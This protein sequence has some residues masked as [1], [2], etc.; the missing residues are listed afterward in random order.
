[1]LIRMTS[2]NGQ[3][4]TGGEGEPLFD[5]CLVCSYLC[6]NNI[7]KTD[8]GRTPCTNTQTVKS[9]QATQWSLGP[10]TTIEG[11]IAKMLQALDEFN[12]RKIDCGF[13]TLQTCLNEHA[14]SELW[15]HST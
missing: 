1:M 6:R 9:V 3:M 10:E 5:D 13:L 14:R 15:E 7:R 11:L 2:I 12:P 8:D 4:K